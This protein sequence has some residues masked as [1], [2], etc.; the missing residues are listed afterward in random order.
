MQKK[1]KSVLR[2]HSIMTGAVVSLLKKEN[3]RLVCLCNN[4]KELCDIV[5]GWNYNVCK[6]IY[7][8]PAA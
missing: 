7:V 2:L 3:L 4:I 5:L 8:S 1:K 6:W